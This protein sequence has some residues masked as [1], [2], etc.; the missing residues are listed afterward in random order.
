MVRVN[1]AVLNFYPVLI[2]YFNIIG[3]GKPKKY[4]MVTTKRDGTKVKE[5]LKPG[6]PR[7]SEIGISKR[8][9]NSSSN[10]VNDKQGTSANKSLGIN[11]N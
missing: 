2:M 6:D 10:I 8:A 3:N 11:Y 5:Y 9:K 4:V 1:S 7:I